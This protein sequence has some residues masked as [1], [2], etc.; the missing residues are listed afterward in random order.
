LGVTPLSAGL[1]AP[2]WGRVVDR[3]DRR[4]VILMACAAAAVCTLLMSVA[5]SPWQLLTLRASM[6]LFG[7]H[8]VAVLA[9]VAGVCPP[10]RLGWALGWLSTAQLAGMLLGPLLGG[11][12]ADAL[13]SY[14]SPF[15]A[16]G[17]ASLVVALAVLRLPKQLPPQTV[18]T[19]P[20]VPTAKML[21]QFPSLRTMVLVLLFAQL[22]MTSVQPIVSLYVSALVGPVPNLATL[23]GVAFSVLG[24][25]GLLAAPW[26]G[27]IG[28]RI[29]RRRL[30]TA[31][32]CGGAA[33]TFVQ[34]FASTYHWF[35][36]ERF[37]AGLFLAGIIPLVNSLVAHT[38]SARDRERAFGLT[39]SA[40]FLGAFVGP[41]GGGLV[42]A[43][44]GVAPVFA[45]ASFALIIAALLIYSMH[46]RAEATNL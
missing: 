4:E 42:N 17:C 9:F 44:F 7:G 39:G 27:R 31:A 11:A 36:M 15:V 37:L 13:H 6:G 10:A 45:S 33:F 35:V 8:I 30:L 3:I 29:G 14:R 34:A 38:V 20:Q 40:T 26:V 28:D 18:H 24:I 21:V 12:I 1:M 23:A 5:T 32:L 46:R 43:R 2:V 16:G 41:F 25:S 19:Q 22:A